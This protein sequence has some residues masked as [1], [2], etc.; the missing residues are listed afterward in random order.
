MKKSLK[1]IL[2]ELN[3]ESPRLDY[4]K[5]MLEV[6]I[7]EEEKPLSRSS[8]VEQTPVKGEVIGSN[9]VETAEDGNGLDAYARANLAAVKSLAEQ[10][11]G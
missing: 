5:G 3:T 11:N 4:I 2:D 9:P 1:K 8:M 6:M 7:D 10:S